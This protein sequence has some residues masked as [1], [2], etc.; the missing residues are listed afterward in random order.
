VGGGGG[1]GGGG[2]WWGWGGVGGGGEEFNRHSISQGKL[3]YFLLYLNI[4]LG[5]NLINR[6]KR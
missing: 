3:S 4:K 1:A 2:R 6:T 5:V